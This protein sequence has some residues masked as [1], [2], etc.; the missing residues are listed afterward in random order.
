MF[1]VTKNARIHKSVASTSFSTAEVSAM[2]LEPG[3]NYFVWPFKVDVIGCGDTV[4]ADFEANGRNRFAHADGYTP[5]DLLS[6]VT[7]LADRHGVRLIVN[8]LNR[9]LDLELRAKARPNPKA[10]MDDA[11]KVLWVITN[12]PTEIKPG[13]TPAD[14]LKVFEAKNV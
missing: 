12:H 6:D 10:K 1:T 14:F 7:V 11:D 4:P 13:M 2:K 9:G 3:S 5:S 8:S